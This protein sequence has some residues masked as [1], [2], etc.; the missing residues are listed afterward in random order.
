MKENPTEFNDDP[1]YE[2]TLEMYQPF[3]PNEKERSCC[4]NLRLSVERDKVRSKEETEAEEDASNF[5]LFQ[6][7]ALEDT[8]FQIFERIEDIG[9]PKE[10]ILDLE[11]EE[12]KE[13]EK[14]KEKIEQK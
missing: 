12:D 6:L 1:S 9:E 13:K 8:F 7:T 3:D 4:R 14:E 10:V 2:T 5:S 11:D